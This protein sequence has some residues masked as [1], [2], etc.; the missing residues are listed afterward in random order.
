MTGKVAGRVV[1]VVID[2]CFV[3]AGT[4]WVIDYKSMTPVDDDVPAFL[5]AQREAH[6]AQLERYATL[7]AQLDPQP[8]RAA[9]YFPSIGEFLELT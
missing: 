8:V 9:L 7:L 5:A 1:N 2:R 6:R 4:R 3:E